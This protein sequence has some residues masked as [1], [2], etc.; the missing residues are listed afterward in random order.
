MGGPKIIYKWKCRFHP[1]TDRFIVRLTQKGIEPKNL[2]HTLS[3]SLHG[4]YQ[5]IALSPIQTIAHN[6]NNGLPFQKGIPV[7]GQ[8]IQKT[9]TYL[10]A[11]RPIGDN[12]RDSKKDLSYF[13][14]FE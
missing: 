3:N 11:S 8:E 13:P 7:L 6:N 5:C 14:L 9:F 4:M 1:G 2:S 10:R 12:F